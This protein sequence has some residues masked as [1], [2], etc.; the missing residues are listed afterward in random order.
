M[1]TITCL[2]LSLSL[3]VACDKKA[4]IAHRAQVRNVATNV[5]EII[6]SQGQL[7]YCLVFTTAKSGTIRQLTRNRDN[8]S[9]K[10]A[11]GEP[12]GR[13]SFKI[14][15]E[16]GP[17]KIHIFFSDRRLDARSV[18][19]QMNQQ[20]SGPEFHPMEYRLPG[21]V[22]SETLEWSPGAE[23]QPT[24]GTVVGSG[25]GRDSAATTSGADAGRSD[26]AL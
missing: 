24:V 19:E 5:I 12:I 18:V 4:P 22:T 21:T 11:A 16:E 8:K 17:V 20:P 15:P 1:R 14:P 3:G 7:P 10:C 13:T 9:V 23:S 25:E 26:G 6:P 2:C